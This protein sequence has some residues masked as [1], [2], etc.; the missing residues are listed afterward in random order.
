MNNIIR[1]GVIVGALEP[2]GERFRGTIEYK[3]NIEAM[4]DKQIYEIQRIKPKLVAPPV[5]LDHTSDTTELVAPCV[6]QTDT[7]KHNES[8]TPCVNQDV[9]S[10]T[11]RVNQD[12]TNNQELIN[13]QITTPLENELVVVFSDQETNS[14]PPT[15]GLAEPYLSEIGNIPNLYISADYLKGKDSRYFPAELLSPLADGLIDAFKRD[16]SLIERFLAMGSDVCMWMVWNTCES[17]RYG[18]SQNDA[19][20]GT[21]TLV[22]NRKYEF[23]KPRSLV[24]YDA[25][26]EAERRALE[27]RDRADKERIDQYAAAQAYY[28]N[29]TPE[30]IQAAKDAIAECKRLSRHGVLLKYAPEPEPKYESKMPAFVREALNK[31]NQPQQGM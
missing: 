6:K 30:Q 5:T 27:R 10:V 12:D 16:T 18:K 21:V 2:F 25:E 3:V 4:C 11:P 22:T 14:Q 7:S 17:M 31:L 13:N 1:W 9:M 23:G 20:A 19:V 24:K 29:R 8:V 28:D 26:I 15:A